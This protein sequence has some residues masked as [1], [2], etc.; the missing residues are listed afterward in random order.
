MVRG[1]ASMRHQPSC[2]VSLSD[3]LG[4]RSVTV[5]SIEAVEVRARRRQAGRVAA[6]LSLA[7]DVVT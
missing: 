6:L 5:V 4:L 2:L 1:H 7:R 3:A